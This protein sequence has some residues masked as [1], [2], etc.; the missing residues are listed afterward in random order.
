MNTYNS[1]NKDASEATHTERNQA[2]QQL[3]GI[4]GHLANRGLGGAFLRAAKAD[5][6]GDMGFMGS[7]VLHAII[8]GP[9]ADFLGEH[10]PHSPWTLEHVNEISMLGSMEAASLLSE[11]EARRARTLRSSFY[12]VGRRKAPIKEAKAK[13]GFNKV[14]ANQN[15]RF[16]L[17]VQS[18][19]ARMFE[20]ID[21]IDQL[22]KQDT[23]K[24]SHKSRQ[25][26]HKKAANGLRIA[27]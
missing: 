26:G 21:M 22:E 2:L 5:P 19:L 27:I 23:G 15:K 25:P 13:R 4:Q 12:P 18:G 10:L 1:A 7:L 6:L 14:A 24:A 11:T 17:E 8:G 16:S 3:A 9:F 20:L